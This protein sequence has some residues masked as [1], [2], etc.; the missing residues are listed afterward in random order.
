MDPQGGEEL[1]DCPGYSQVSEICRDGGFG[2]LTRTG[3]RYLD[4]Y[5]AGWVE[6]AS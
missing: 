2:I 3:G 4:T 1:K 6:T 5:D